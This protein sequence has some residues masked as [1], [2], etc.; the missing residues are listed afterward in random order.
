MKKTK[1][2][3][4]IGPAS[5][6]EGVVERMIKSGANVFRLNF[7]HGTHED[8]EKAV[9]LI[10]KVSKRLQIPVGIL[11]DLS[12]PKIRIGDF[13]TE[14]ITLK[15]NQKFVLTTKA[16]VGDEHK[17]FVS[18][19]NLPKEVKK[20]TRIMLDD[21][22]RELEVTRV[23]GGD[24]HTKVLVGGTIR[25]RRGVNVPGAYLSIKT[26]TDKDIAD[27][28]LGID[29]HVDFIA[30]SFVRTS[31]SL[32]RIRR[33]LEKHE[34]RAMVIAKIETAEAVEHIDEIIDA[35]DGILIARGDLAIEIP[36]ED[37]PIVQK[38]IVAKCNQAGKPVIVAT[39]MLESMIVSPVPTRAE[40]SD[41]ANAVYEGTSAL[42]LSGE[43]AVGQHPVTAVRMMN[44]VA[45][46]AEGYHVSHTGTARKS[47]EDVTSA[48]D[49]VDSITHSV[50]ESAKEL[51]VKAI[52][53]LTES[54]FTA[55]ML[56][57]HHPKQKIIVMTPSARTV[58]QAT[59]AFGCHP[60]QIKS[61]RYVSQVV[62]KVRSYV[63]EQG[64][65]SKG[66]K[67]IIA[68][69]VPFGVH[70]GTNMMMVITV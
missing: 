34:S 26:L 28:Q 22:Q 50:F 13:S 37:V 66:D 40:V 24:I 8:H 68:A 39:Q 11:Q 30:L 48:H 61:F 70:G 69:G 57:R 56:S 2:V 47:H 49:V 45:K 35:A 20:G 27:M 7:S 6:D 62:G 21:G 17:V 65:A 10:C 54:G 46:K 16:Y 23:I 52:V 4:T 38:E 5:M 12:G 3:A 15:R 29:Q 1:I 64:F 55:R 32:A 41:I 60:L 19:R 67:V 33:I 31:K 58:R 18:Y 25:G 36:R 53:A 14:T 42:M 43:T 51:N 9:K 63:Q 59:L 44:T